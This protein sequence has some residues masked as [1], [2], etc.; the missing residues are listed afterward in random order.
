MATAE[1]KIQQVNSDNYNPKAKSITSN[2]PIS[3]R[4]PWHAVVF[5][6][7]VLAVSIHSC[8]SNISSIDEI[9]VLKTWTHRVFPSLISLKALGWIRICIA[10][11]IWFVMGQ[12]MVSDG[13]IQNT[14]DHLQTGFQIK[15]RCHN[16]H[17]R[18]SHTL[19]F[20]F[21]VLDAIGDFFCASWR[22]GSGSGL[23]GRGV[24]TRT[25][26]C[27]PLDFAHHTIDLGDSSSLCFSGIGCHSI[28]HLAN[29]I[30]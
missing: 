6:L 26:L 9:A 29:G 5:V 18:R 27:P 16:T 19:S 21:M 13:W 12:T 24:C 2:I 30:V 25:A 8:R 10:T 14:D 7:S 3:A 28:L 22:I 23:Q 17:E 20:H 1:D 11:I 4:P 15:A